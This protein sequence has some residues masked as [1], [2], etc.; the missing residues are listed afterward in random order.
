MIKTYQAFFDALGFRESSSIAGGVQNYHIE[1]RFGFIGKYQFGEAAL[2]DLGYYS[3]DRSDSNLFKNDWTGNWSGKSGIFSKQDY[4]NNGSVQEIIIQDWHSTLWSRIQKLELDQYAGQVLNGIPITASGMLAA[5]H[6]IGAG[7]SSSDSAGLKG[8]LLSGAQISPQDGN[9][10]SAND[11]MTLF[12]DFATPFEIDD[13]KDYVIKGGTG[14]DILTGFGGNDALVGNDG[15]DIARYSGNT[16]DY[17]VSNHTDGT[18]S[19]EHKVGTE[20]RDTLTQIERI[21]FA[22]GAR[23]LD[24]DDH[25]GFVAKTL[26][27]VFGKASISNKNF[28]GI[29]LNLLD[30]GISN[31]ALMQLAMN[32]ALGTE[33]SN[34]NAAVELLYTNIVGTAPSAQEKS[35]YVEQLDTGVHTIASIGVWA[36]DTTLNQENIDLVGVAQNGLD[37]LPVSV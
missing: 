6:L 28:V 2:F 19:V 4:F 29:G 25:A 8:Y 11:Y 35:L 13:D 12:A 31:E 7:S 32:E 22:D 24:F 37:Y 10:T 27:A 18:W 20:G 1:N 21:E 17:V 5:S 36:A 34:H 16:T 3:V 15:I 14:H 26:G 9:G 23:A 30:E 33:A